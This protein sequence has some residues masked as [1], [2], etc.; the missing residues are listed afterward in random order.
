MACI[1]LDALD[2]LDS[3]DDLLDQSQRAAVESKMDWNV[4]KAMLD[5]LDELDPL[6]PLV[7]VADFGRKTR[8]PV[9]NELDSLDVLDT[10]PQ[11][12]GVAA[13]LDFISHSTG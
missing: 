7:R 8:K 4:G 9:V 13:P 3:L 10:F 5:E 2:S 11:V 1:K 12:E 6:D